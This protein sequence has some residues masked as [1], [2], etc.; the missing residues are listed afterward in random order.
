MA[1]WTGYDPRP[2]VVSQPSPAPSPYAAPFPPLPPVRHVQPEPPTPRE[3]LV[4]RL[5]GAA[6]MLVLLSVTGYLW[7]LDWLF[8]VLFTIYTA[9]AAYWFWDLF[10]RKSP[11]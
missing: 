6:L 5:V 3:I 4:Q 7:N 9:L 10:V 1:Q 11:F 2:Q 8:R